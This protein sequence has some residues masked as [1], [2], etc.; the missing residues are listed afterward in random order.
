VAETAKVFLKIFV[1]H[2]VGLDVIK[3]HLRLCA[4]N[5]KV[6]FKKT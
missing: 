2:A 5:I 4:F 1:V 6:R 3:E